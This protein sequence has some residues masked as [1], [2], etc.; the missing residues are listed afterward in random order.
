[1][2]SFSRSINETIASSAIS[3]MPKV[4]SPLAAVPEI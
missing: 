2:D 3:S 4:A 1:M